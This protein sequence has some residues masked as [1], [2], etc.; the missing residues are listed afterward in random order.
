VTLRF[1]EGHFEKRGSRVFDVLLEGKTV[2]ETY[3]PLASGFGVPDVRSFSVEVVDGCL[4]LDFAVRIE[5]P[6][7]SAIEI[8]REDAPQQANPPPSM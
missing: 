3:E 2:L 4:D 1:I 5:N 6:K 8:F 7:I